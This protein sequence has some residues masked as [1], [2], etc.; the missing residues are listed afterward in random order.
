MEVKMKKAK[1][2]L[3]ELTYGEQVIGW[4]V[5]VNFE[6]GGARD[7]ESILVDT[8]E[9]AGEVA[10]DMVGD[11]YFKPGKDE[12]LVIIRDTADIVSVKIYPR[13][14]TIYVE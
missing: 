1:K 6:R 2:D 8:K 7:Y 11:G 13:T 10:H 4:Y 3:T 5:G 12:R 14:R 9:R